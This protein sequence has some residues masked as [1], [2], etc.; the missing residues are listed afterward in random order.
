MLRAVLSKYLMQHPPNSN[1]TA[2]Y[3][4]SQTILENQDTRGTAGELRSNS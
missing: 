2:A 1:F 4:Q 3:F